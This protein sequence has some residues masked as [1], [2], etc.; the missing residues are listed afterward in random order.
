MASH[1]KHFYS[2]EEYLAL[3][4]KASYKSEYYAGE[5]FALS[6]ASRA[7]NI[8]VANVTTSLNTQLE[9][10]DCEVYPNDMRVRTPDSLLY[11]YPDVVVVCGEPQFEDDSVDTLLNPTL[12]VE[13]L[14]PSTEMRDR[15]KKFADYRKITSL[16]EYILV[17]Q[18]ECRVT[19]YV[20]QAS[21]TWLFQEASH[22]KEAL[23]L[24]SIDCDLVLERIYRK[25]RFSTQGEKLS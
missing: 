17:A 14:S 8:I 12:L 16:R 4:C 2:S 20:R 18:E 1:P 25:V 7:H 9:H 11:T 6:G 5:I 23:H 19:Q 15:T 24:A 21:D 22:L 10:R 13:V 3:E